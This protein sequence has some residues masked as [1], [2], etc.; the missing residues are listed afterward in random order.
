MDYHGCPKKLSIE[1]V[2]KRNHAHFFL[3]KHCVEC[4]QQFHELDHCEIAT[5]LSIMSIPLN[6]A[7]SLKD[8]TFK[9]CFS[10]IYL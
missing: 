5:P 9:M 8:A 4:F 2:Q 6:S 10:I 1:L 7:R 3:K